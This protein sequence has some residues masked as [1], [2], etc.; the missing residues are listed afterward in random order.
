MAAWRLYTDGIT[1]MT[2]G[3]RRVSGGCSCTQ[4]DEQHKQTFSD[5]TGHSDGRME[6]ADS[7]LINGN[8]VCVMGE[9]D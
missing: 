6:C 1:G 5:G 2:M 8:C 3:A 9:G 7:C 4:Q